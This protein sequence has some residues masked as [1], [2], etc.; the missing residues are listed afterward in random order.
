MGQ[1]EKCH[2]LAVSAKGHLQDDLMESELKEEHRH[3][4]PSEILDK[5]RR[6][7]TVTEPSDETNDNAL[8][9]GRRS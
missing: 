7:I 6:L 8:T 4:G 5:R 3:T 9:N 2:S 1:S